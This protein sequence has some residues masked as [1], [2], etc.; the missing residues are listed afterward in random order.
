MTL[1]IATAQILREIDGDTFVVDALD[2]GWGINV[3]PTH[4][5]DQ[6]CHIRLAGVNCPDTRPGARWYDPELAREAT[7]YFASAY[8]V[9]T[10]VVLTSYGID[11]F[12]RTLATAATTRSDGSLADIG[13]DLQARG[14]AR[15]GDYPDPVAES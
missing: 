2:P 14:L 9:G 4:P 12:G 3:L 8:P 13:A 1:R 15:E 6:R 11:S 5:S 10:K 7:A